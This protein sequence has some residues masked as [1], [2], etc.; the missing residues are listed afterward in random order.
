MP[1]PTSSLDG[2]TPAPFTGG[3]LTYDVYT[4]GSGPG[5]VLIPEIPGLT[6]EVLGLA[7]H[8]VES[9]FTV[10]VPSLFGTPGKPLSP[11]YGLQTMAK[12]CVASE[13]K[14]FAAG[15]ARPISAF[16]RALA[17]DLN[18]RTP[19]RGVGVIG[20]CFT[21]GFALATAVDDSV[22]AA[23]MSQPSVPFS[24]SS[25]RKRDIGLSPAEAQTVQQRTKDGLCL[26]G[27]KFSEDKAF[28]SQR[29]DAY[30][31][32]FGD[33]IELIVLDSSK[34]NPDGYSSTAHSVLTGEVRLDPP[35]SAL[36]ARER[37]VAFLTEHVPG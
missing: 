4:K 6:P 1:A 10:A 15:A 33:A 25:A 17:A 36:A 30:R 24:V 23:V 14:A 37:V 21:G 22:L 16:L 12:L 35:N 2:W 34:G 3:G 27:L 26:M 31:Q 19:G 9:G 20:M 13:M 32:T 8:L 5:V 18:T 28:S 29:F 11:G 7:D